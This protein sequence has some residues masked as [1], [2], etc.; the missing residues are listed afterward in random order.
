[1]NKIA[2]SSSAW[3][4]Y[5]AWQS[6]DKRVLAK[7]NALLK[8]IGRNVA[9]AGIGN[10]EALTGNLNGFFSRRINE[11]DRLVYEFS[12]DGCVVV[13]QCKGHYSDR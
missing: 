5:L 13:V 11:T 2:F 9:L 4:E 7:I 12:D 3:N 8:D 6:E 10:P 1:M